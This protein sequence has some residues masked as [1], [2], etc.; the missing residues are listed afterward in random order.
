MSF[1]NTISRPIIAP[2]PMD[3]VTDAAYRYIVDVYGKPSLLITEFTN[4]EGLSRGIVKLLHSFMYHTSDTPTLAQIYGFTPENFYNAGI[5]VAEMGFDGIDINMG[6][7]DK[8][9]SSRGAGAGLIRTPKIAQEILRAVK[10]ASHDFAEGKTIDD[11]P[12]SD[13]MK[14]WIKNFKKMHGRHAEL[15]S[16][17]HGIPN[18]VRDDDSPR[19]LPVSV[20]TRMGYDDIVTEDWIKNLLET[21]PAAITLHG[22]TLKQMYT[23][24]ANWDEIGKAAQIVKQTD[25]IFLGNGDVKTITEAHE[26]IKTYGL[27]GVLIGRASFGNPWLFRSHEPTSKEQI[28]VAMEHCKAFMRLTPDGHFASLRKHLAW[29]TK[30]IRNSNE[31][32]NELMKVGTVEDVKRTFSNF[33]V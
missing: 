14:T 26:K 25:T 16:A 7:P 13:E 3:G 11:T 31:V 5:L 24:A 29:Y 6:C 33:S 9:I 1:W 27:D 23:G 2:A 10:Q 19:L 21:E 18:R 22:R 20:K 30:G 15:D 28:E 32:R 17:S 12:L 8:S 4:V